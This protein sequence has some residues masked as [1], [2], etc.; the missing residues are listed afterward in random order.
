M[1][2]SL[3]SILPTRTKEELGRDRLIAHEIFA[4]VRRG[5]NKEKAMREVLAKYGISSQDDQTITSISNILVHELRWHDA[6]ANPQ[7]Q[8]L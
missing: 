4:L 7:G 6:D 2:R 5:E 3:E 1:P 8:L